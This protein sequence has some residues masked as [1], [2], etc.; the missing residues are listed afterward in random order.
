MGEEYPADDQEFG[1][2]P[3]NLEV[4]MGRAAGII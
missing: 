1:F 3:I 2:D 4:H